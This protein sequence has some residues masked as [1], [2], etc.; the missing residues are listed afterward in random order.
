MCWK[1]IACTSLDLS[2]AEIRKLQMVF[3]DAL[4]TDQI[5]EVQKVVVT[6]HIRKALSD[7]KYGKRTAVSL[8]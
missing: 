7:E 5:P 6:T 1:H 2:V 8:T 4:E 3:L